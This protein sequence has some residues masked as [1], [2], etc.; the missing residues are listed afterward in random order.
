MSKAGGKERESWW[1]WKHLMSESVRE[2]HRFALRSRV[3][4]CSWT[5]CSP[6]DG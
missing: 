5:L 1:P 4:V 3:W 6:P 2:E